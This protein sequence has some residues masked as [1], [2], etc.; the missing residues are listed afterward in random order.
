[1]SPN[2]GNFVH[3]LVEMAK[4]MELLPQVQ[5]DLQNANVEAD[6]LRSAVMERENRIVDLNAEIEALHAEVRDAEGRADKAETMFLEADDRTIA[7]LS[8]IKAQFGAAGALIQAL[9]PPKPVVVEPAS[10]VSE[11]V[12]VEG[13]EQV[14]AEPVS[15]EEALADPSKRHDMF[16]EAVYYEKHE[17]QSGQSESLPPAQ[18]M[19]VQSAP[20]AEPSRQGSATELTPTT[21]LETIAKP[22]EGKFYYDLLVYVSLSD[23]IAGGGTEQGYYASRPYIAPYGY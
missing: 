13:S 7:A 6:R 9:E 2:V 19:E 20:T 16:P 3:D 21:G 17:P 11:T 23:W 4:A 10:A 18:S 15:M 12:T 22:F 5:L 14:Q 1:M 8:F